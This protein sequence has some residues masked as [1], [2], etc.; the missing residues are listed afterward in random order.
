MSE[1]SHS[2][3]AYFSPLH[4]PAARAYSHVCLPGAQGHV[5]C[6]HS[7]SSGKGR[8]DFGWLPPVSTTMTKSQE[9]PLQPC[10]Q[11]ST[12][13]PHPTEDFSQPPGSRCKRVCVVDQR[14]VRCTREIDPLAQ[15]LSQTHCVQEYDRGDGGSAPRWVLPTDSFS[16]ASH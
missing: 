2:D 12:P 14:L 3:A 6:Y 13:H 16:S 1:T 7:V 10:R 11:T 9:F 15:L 8:A 5:I 4:G